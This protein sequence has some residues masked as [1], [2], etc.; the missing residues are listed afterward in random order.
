[1]KNK[2]YSMNYRKNKLFALFSAGLLCLLLPALVLSCVST[3]S[4]VSA[5]T[6]SVEEPAPREEPEKPSGIPVEKEPAFDRYAFASALV[7]ML[8]AGDFS[9]ALAYFDSIPEP[10]ASSR[11]ILKLKLS[12]LISSGDLKAASVLADALEAEDKNDTEVL[13]SQAVI[14]LAKNKTQDRSRYLK[15]IVEI[16]PENTEAMMTLAED[17]LGKKAYGDART[18]YQK[19]V[20]VDPDNIHALT[21][22]V[23]AYYMQNKMGEARTVINKAIADNPDA[24]SLWAERAL[25]N[26]EE[27]KNPAALSDIRQAIALDPTVPAYWTNYGIFLLKASKLGEALDAFNEAIRLNPDDYFPYIYRC[28]V[29]DSLGNTEE[30]L[31]DYR[32]VCEKY[33]QYY[34]AAEG[35]GGLLWLQGDYAG[36]K[37]AFAQAN[38]YAPKDA[39]YA[40]MYTLCCYHLGEKEE[41]KK[42]IGKFMNT[43]D[44]SS[45]EY[46]VCRL[47]YDKTGDSDVV[48]RISREKDASFRAKYMFYIASFYELF[49]P[50]SSLAEKIYSEITEVQG[51]SFFEHRLAEAR[52]KKVSTEISSVTDGN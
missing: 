18:W 38:K 27:K 50:A 2:D 47:F 28:G 35:L 25:I 37:A 11:D 12:V 36:A 24:A 49:Q 22:L 33:P 46:F 32:F 31:S 29:N 52:L 51:P 45:T 5:D 15:K 40:L 44:R 14:A 42:F 3:G 7:D 1:M 41:A 8:E 9:G 19:A 10:E 17:S 16:D 48:G 13:Y 23:H 30:A 26:S 21:G 20:E 39:S 34:Y 4:A 43:L 6:G